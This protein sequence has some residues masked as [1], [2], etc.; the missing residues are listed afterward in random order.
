MPS[1][2]KFSFCITLRKIDGDEEQLEDL[3]LEGLK[4]LEMDALG[5]N[6]SRGYGQVQFQFDDKELEKKFEKIQPFQGE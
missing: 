1:G 3:L 5:G 6:G 2:V 4:L